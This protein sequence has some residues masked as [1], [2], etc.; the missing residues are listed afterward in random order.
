MSYTGIP[1]ESES[2]SLGWNFF[3]ANPDRVWHQTRLLEEPVW[4]KRV[5][6]IA[7]ICGLAHRISTEVAVGNVLI[8]WNNQRYFTRCESIC[9][10]VYRSCPPAEYFVLRVCQDS[11]KGYT[12]ASGSHYDSPTKIFESPEEFMAAALAVTSAVIN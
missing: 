4:R 8:E 9:Y 11:V 1:S 2:D 10:R 7:Q 12:L 5:S 3:A 6:A